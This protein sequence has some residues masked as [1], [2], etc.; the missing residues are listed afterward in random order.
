MK[1]IQ[2]TEKLVR[3]LEMICERTVGTGFD[4][5]YA[6]LEDLLFYHVVDPKE[7]GWGTI[8]GSK[9]GIDWLTGLEEL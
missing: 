6:D 2:A 7:E 1:E 5:Y 3:K 8:E 4:K 9:E